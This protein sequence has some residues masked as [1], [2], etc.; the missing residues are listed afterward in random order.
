MQSE[1]YLWHPFSSFILDRKLLAVTVQGLHMPY[2]CYLAVGNVLSVVLQTIAER[3][4][5]Y[6]EE[7]AEQAREVDRLAS[8]KV[9][10]CPHKLWS[11]C[12]TL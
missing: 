7:L 12:I 4:Q 5:R 8:R 3:E 1:T 11:S 6:Q 10:V 2:A 9:G